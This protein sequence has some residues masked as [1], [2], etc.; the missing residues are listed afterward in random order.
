MGLQR[1]LLARA[2][3]RQPK[4][5]FMDEG[6]AHLDVSTERKVNES[7]ASL[8]ITKIIIAHRPE[9]IQYAKRVLLL[10]DGVL[11]DVSN[12]GG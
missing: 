8:G 9:T 6:T 11:E 3:Y 4:I 1:I 5:L 2:L 10:C 12:I 7:I